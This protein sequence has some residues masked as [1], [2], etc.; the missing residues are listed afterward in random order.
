MMRLEPYRL[1]AKQLFSLL[2]GALLGL[3]IFISP[4]QL[5]NNPASI[6]ANSKA[7][8]Q[9]HQHH[10]SKEIP[11]DLKC[12]RCVLQGFQAPE[13]IAPFIVVI[14]VLGFLSFGKA[15]EPFSFITLV[16][17]ARAPPLAT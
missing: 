5:H 7:T 6:F 15:N 1:N 12:L 9:E 11:K 4:Y 2:L 10:N 3:A 17:A 8:S 14:V 13:V 16:N